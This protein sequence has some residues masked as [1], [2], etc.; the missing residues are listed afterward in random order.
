MTYAI[1]RCAAEVLTAEPGV[2]MI[3]REP[4]RQQAVAEWE[5]YPD[6][7]LRSALHHTTRSSLV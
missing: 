1:R 5:R 6:Y 2:S 4:Y 3:P 7:G